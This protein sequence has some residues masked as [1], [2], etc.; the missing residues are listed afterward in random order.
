MSV[1]KQLA[2]LRV[3]VIGD[4]NG[5]RA[6]LNDLNGLTV[7]PPPLYFDLQGV[8]LGR[9]GSISVVTLYILPKKTVY[10]IDMLQLGGS[11]FSMTTD[12]GISLETILE[13]KNIPK[14]FFD[15][16][17]ALDALFN[18]YGISV[19]G[20]H[21]VQ[22]MELATRKGSKAIRHEL[23]EC[24]AKDSPTLIAEDLGWRLVNAAATKLLDPERGGRTEI[25][26]ERPIRGELIWYCAQKVTSLPDL[27]KKY[28][29]SLSREWQK[30]SQ[31]KVESATSKLIALSKSASYKEPGMDGFWGSDYD[32]KRDI[33][34]WR[35]KR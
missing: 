34:N 33:N 18:L 17:N 7:K 12:K 22:V 14:V 32:I 24:V 11:A 3:E 10:L 30:I 9:H 13:T 1:S 35:A 25:L 8:E 29:A 26:D 15:S 31:V 20:F 2:D 19:E 23:D 27:F 4:V 16:L 6:V 28:D 21:D 5:L